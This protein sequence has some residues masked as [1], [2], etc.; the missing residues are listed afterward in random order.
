MLLDALGGPSWIHIELSASR[1][2]RKFVKSSR[3]LEAAT[4]LRVADQRWRC[5]RS[6]VAY[7]RCNSF[8]SR[9]P[10]R[11][12]RLPVGARRHGDERSSILD[13]K[14]AARYFGEGGIAGETDDD[15]CAA[16]RISDP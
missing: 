1:Q 8:S 13:R 10:Q 2:L 5:F 7:E 14:V 6:S 9:L 4:R 11:L 16:F 12:L 15:P 3:S